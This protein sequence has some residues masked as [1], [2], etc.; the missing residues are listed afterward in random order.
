LDLNRI[1]ILKL[2]LFRFGFELDFETK[3][4]DL[5]KY[6]SVHIWQASVSTKSKP[7]TAFQGICFHIIRQTV[8]LRNFCSVFM[9][10][11]QNLNDRGYAMK[12][13]QCLV[14]SLSLQF[15]NFTEKKFF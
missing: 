6:K 10:G 14:F 2:S 4:L 8:D 5:I 7:N 15:R 1:W 13:E 12:S 9:P 3:L 11:A